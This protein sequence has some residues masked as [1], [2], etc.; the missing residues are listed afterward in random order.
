MNKQEL[1]A[2]ITECRKAIEHG[3]IKSGAFGLHIIETM[4]SDS[5]CHQPE[6]HVIQMDAA[7]L[8]EPLEAMLDN[9]IKKAVSRKPGSCPRCGNE[10]FSPGAKFCKICGMAVMGS[11]EGKQCN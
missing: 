9:L 1:I 8:P 5:T 4:L 7:D 6:L 2:A 3:G 11:K 10:E